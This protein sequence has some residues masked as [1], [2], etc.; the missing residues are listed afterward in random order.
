MLVIIIASY[1][2]YRVFVLSFMKEYYLGIVNVILHP[3]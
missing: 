3:C 2:Y 1:F